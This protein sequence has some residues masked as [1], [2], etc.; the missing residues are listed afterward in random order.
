MPDDNDTKATY[1]VMSPEYETVLPILDDGTG[2]SEIARDVVKVQAKTKAEAKRSGYAQLKTQRWFRKHYEH[3][4]H[5]YAYL[6][7]ECSPDLSEEDEH[8]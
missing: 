3:D 8:A 6:T 2:P 7:V 1:Y 4:K 5:P